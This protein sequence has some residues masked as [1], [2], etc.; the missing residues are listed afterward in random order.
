VLV[1]VFMHLMARGTIGFDLALRPPAAPHRPAFF[2]TMH[3]WF[4]YYLLIF[5][6]VAAGAVRFEQHLPAKLKG[7]WH[8]AWGGMTGNWWGALL[9][10]VPLALVGMKYP[11]GMVGPDGSFIPNG[12]ELLHNGMFFLF[13][14]S[15]Y[16]ERTSL[17]DRY[18]RHC[19]RSLAAGLVTF[20]VVLKLF[21]M[22]THSNGQIANLNACIAFMYG[23]TSWLWSIGLIGL[24]VRYL[25]HQNRFLRY[26]SDSSYWVF[27][28][29]MLGTVGFGVLLYNAPLGA[30]PKMAI[31]IVATTAACLLTYH[32]VVRTTWI[33]VLL[34]GKRHAAA[35]GENQIKGAS[36][37]R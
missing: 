6:I 13:G 23:M 15:L 14:W 21:G 34:N 24:F 35:A 12:A 3:M 7:A 27:L 33:G 18:A 31:N 20:I 4:I 22:A 5:C 32:Y 36:T 37:G 30:L 26:V 19:W 8:A 16:R 25:P 2:G 28:V 1:L 9:L 29:H 17:L 10:S 11:G